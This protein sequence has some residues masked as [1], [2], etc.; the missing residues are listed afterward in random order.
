MNGDARVVHSSR[1]MRW[2][3]GFSLIELLCVIALAIILAGCCC[4]LMGAYSSV[5]RLGV[6]SKALMTVFRQARQ[7]ALLQGEAIAVCGA[8]SYQY[9]DSQWS[10]G[11]MLYKPERDQFLDH[12]RTPKGVVVHCSPRKLQQGPRFNRIGF[13]AA[14]QGRC[15]LRLTSKGRQSR[16]IVLSSSGRVRLQYGG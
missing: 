11:Q 8:S 4:G 7:L 14:Q 1:L 9:C 3:P 16:Q 2:Q 15:V 12:Y 10:A 5:V 13:A 6:A